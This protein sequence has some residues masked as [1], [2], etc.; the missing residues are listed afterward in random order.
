MKRIEEALDSVHRAEQAV[1]ELARQAVEQRDYAAAIS[2]TNLAAQLRS[3]SEHAQA[4]P[5]AI[6]PAEDSG[7]AGTA[8]APDQGDESPG[9]QR[10][11]RRRP[12][13]GEF[14]RFLRDERTLFKLGWSK[15]EKAVYEH[16][17]PRKVLVTLV[18]KFVTVGAN[19]RRFTMEDVF[20]LANTSDD[21]EIPN[22]Q[23]YLCLAWLRTTSL[24]TQH[25]R[26]GYSI[27]HPSRFEAEVESHWQRIPLRQDTQP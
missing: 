18:K 16:K 5:D 3:V 1:A 17:A 21:S 6:A 23:V 25:G 7:D 15:A 4:S 2:L 19:R 13:K 26:Q 24:L 22:Y 20:P 12:R 27:A 9:H 14:P 10:P 8:A 11:A